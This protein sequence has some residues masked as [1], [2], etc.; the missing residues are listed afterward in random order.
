MRL[1][2][3]SLAASLALEPSAKFGIAGRVAAS[4]E[5]LLLI[6]AR[7]EVQKCVEDR[8]CFCAGAGVKLTDL[9]SGFKFA[10]R[11]SDDSSFPGEAEMQ[12]SGG[13]MITRGSSI[14]NTPPA[15]VASRSAAALPTVE[16]LLTEMAG[17]TS[18]PSAPCGCRD[19]RSLTS[20]EIGIVRIL[21]EDDFRISC[22]ISR[23]EIGEMSPPKGSV[24]ASTERCSDCMRTS[25][26]TGLLSP[27]I[28][29]AGGSN[30]EDASRSSVSEKMEAKLAFRS[31][32]ATRKATTSDAVKM[33]QTAPSWL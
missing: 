1:D 4:L 20:D 30:S 17:R 19:L 23:D 6:E 5:A 21:R 31:A 27:E 18:F 28:I 12:D 25:A 9:L 26:S 14:T 15:S 13:V 7:D 32:S 2:L 29:A 24:T 22:E 11:E 16:E 3:R 33:P 8:R 10:S